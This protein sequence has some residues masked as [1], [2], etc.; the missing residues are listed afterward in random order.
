MKHSSPTQSSPVYFLTRVLPVVIGTEG[1]AVS[2]S[3]AF[4]QGWVRQEGIGWGGV[5]LAADGEEKLE[6]ST[7]Q[8]SW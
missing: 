6:V 4:Y 3:R 5:Q 2:A 1:Q 7:K 8:L